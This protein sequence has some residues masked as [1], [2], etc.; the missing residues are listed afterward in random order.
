MRGTYGVRHLLAT[1]KSELFINSGQLAIKHILRGTYRMVGLKTATS[2]TIALLFRTIRLPRHPALT[3]ST[4]REISHPLSNGMRDLLYRKIYVLSSATTLCL[5]AWKI[6]E[7]FSKFP[8][9]VIV[10]LYF[11][12]RFQ[13]MTLKYTGY[14]MQSMNLSPLCHVNDQIN[15]PLAV[16]QS[17]GHFKAFSGYFHGGTCVTGR[18]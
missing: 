8:H 4:A 2:H 6:A 1:K 13:M 7:I 17:L 12:F 11:P 15:T 9:M 14:G 18:H 10:S 16:G 5:N 3:E